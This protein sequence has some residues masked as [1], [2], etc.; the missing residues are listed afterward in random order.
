[1]RRTPL[2]VPSPPVRSAYVHAASGT[3][4]RTD[5]GPGHHGFVLAQPGA[6][7]HPAPLLP[8]LR[9]GPEEMGVRHGRILGSASHSLAILGR[10]GGRPLIAFVRADVE[11]GPAVERAVALPVGD[12]VG[13][14]WLSGDGRTLVRA[15]LVPAGR[16]VAP[17]YYRAAVSSLEDVR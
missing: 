11:G 9:L 2:A 13:E 8:T 16:G 12:R 1:M 15:E 17:V 6:P 4:W 3:L 5:D 14:V 10:R 7:A